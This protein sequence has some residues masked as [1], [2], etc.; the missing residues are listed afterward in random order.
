MAKSKNRMFRV[1][2]I[3]KSW[4]EIE[5]NALSLDDALDY[6]KTLKGDDFIK[7]QGEL[8]DQSF[9]LVGVQADFPDLH[10]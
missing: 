3:I 8:N 7:P 1:S 10:E 5:V 2:A 4:V 9:Q 6:A